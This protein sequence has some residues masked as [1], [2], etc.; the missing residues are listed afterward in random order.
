MIVFFVLSTEFNFSNLNFEGIVNDLPDDLDGLQGSSGDAQTSQGSQD[1]GLGGS[2]SQLLSRS[3]NS[4]TSLSMPI[5]SGGG[6]QS[7]SPSIGMIMGKGPMTN[8]L[9]ATLTNANKVA[10]SSHMGMN[11]GLV[12]NSSFTISGTN[13]GLMGGVA[14]S[15]S[16]KPMGTQQMIGG[17][18]SLNMGQQLLQN[19]M[20]NGPGSFANNLG[21]MRGMP[22]NVNPSTSMQMPQTGMMSNP[23]MAQMQPH[24]GISG[25]ANLNMQQQQAVSQMVR[26]SCQ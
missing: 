20:M 8:N 4:Q 16:M 23:G 13:P 19:Q 12:S 18:G 17:V 26:V 22:N 3:A 5:N 15:I 7:R 24:Q 14:N 2:L 1:S 21:Q 10:T 11:D 9:A 25:H 6:V